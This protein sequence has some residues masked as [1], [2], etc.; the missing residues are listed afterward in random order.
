VHTDN[1]YFDEKGKFHIFT[2]YSSPQEIQNIER[3]KSSKY[4]DTYIGKYTI[5]QLLRKYRP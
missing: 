1:V 4:E 2:L 5:I 3:I